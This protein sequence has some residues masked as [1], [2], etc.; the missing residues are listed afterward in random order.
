M[1]KKP[2]KNTEDDLL[3]ELLEDCEASETTDVR[4]KL[5]NNRPVLDI[6][7]DKIMGKEEV[8]VLL[9]AISEY[10][11]LKTE[12]KTTVRFI[13]NSF[14]ELFGEGKTRYTLKDLKKDFVGSGYFRHI[15]ILSPGPIALAELHEFFNNEDRFEK[16]SPRSLEKHR[17]LEAPYEKKEPEYMTMTLGNKSPSVP[18]GNDLWLFDKKNQQPCIIEYAVTPGGAVSLSI[19]A[20]DRYRYTL[21]DEVKEKV[22]RSPYF[23]GQVIEMSN[24][25]MRIVKEFNNECPIMDQ[26]LKE[27]LEKNIINLFRKRKEIKLY[28]LASKRTILLAGRPGNGKTMVCRWLANE[29]KGEVTTLW[30]SSKSIYG[31]QDIEVVFD[32]ARKMSPVLL[33]IED[34]DLIV[35]SRTRDPETL[36]EM[37]QQL[38][39]LNKNDELIILASTNRVFSLDEALRSRPGRIDRI[40]QLKNPSEWQAERIARSFL[41]KHNIP[42]ETVEKLSFPHIKTSEL[43]GA[44]I[45]SIM[46]GAIFEAIHRNCQINDLC[47]STSHKNIMEQ[48]EK[49]S[50]KP[51]K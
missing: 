12:L 32:L 27:E 19:E 18:V 49:F 44:Q 35:G 11:D 34:I 31:P 29:L 46:E 7:N 40:Y 5:K 2:A 47:I 33:I 39:G 51:K 9:N 16:I 28:N 6:L 14:P 38:D 30:V 13:Q 42:E 41:I 25:S 22:E 24:G 21:L 48:R 50:S 1:P 15:E 20:V 8:G 26:S 4:Q 17:R 37:L 23:R 3:V 36:G 45:V 10:Q 43:T